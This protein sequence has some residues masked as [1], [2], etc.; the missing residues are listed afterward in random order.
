[1]KGHAGDRNLHGAC[2]MHRL[3]EKASP[4]TVTR[5]RG[6]TWMAVAFLVV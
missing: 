1:M 6:E 2:S 4:T 5:L 3:Y